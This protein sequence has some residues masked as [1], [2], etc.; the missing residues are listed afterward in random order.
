M[1]RSL[2]RQNFLAL[3]TSEGGHFVP[4]FW[5]SSCRTCPLLLMCAG[6]AGGSACVHKLPAVSAH[7]HHSNIQVKRRSTHASQA[8]WHVH[9]GPVLTVL[10]LSCFAK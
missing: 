2:Y 7:L 9:G 8:P 10:D 6:T 3:R 1:I 5:Q 4:A